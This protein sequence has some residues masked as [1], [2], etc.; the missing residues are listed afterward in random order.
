MKHRQWGLLL[1]NAAFKWFIIA[2]LLRLGAAVAIHQYSLANGFEGFYPLASGHD[3]I[4]YWKNANEV[5]NGILREPFLNMYPYILAG[6]FYITGPN[7]L[8]GKIL[9]VLFGALGV[10]FGV[11]LARELSLKKAG[12]AQSVRTAHWAGIMLT[13]YPS[14]VFYST[15]LLKD[16]A[17][18]LLA[19][20]ALYLMNRIA[21]IDSHIKKIGCGALLLAA[22]WLLYELR[23][24]SALVLLL[25]IVAYIL[26]F[27]RMAFILIVIAAGVFPY[28]L[29]YGF[30]GCDY[31]VPY[32]HK[33]AIG[34]QNFRETVYS[35][36]GSAAGNQLDFSSWGIFLKTYFFSFATLMFGPFPWQLKSTVHLIAMPEAAVMWLLSP[37]WFIGIIRLFDGLRRGMADKE[38]VLMIFS[39]GL[40]GAVALFSDNIGANTRLRILPWNVFMIYASLLLSQIKFPTFRKKG[41]PLS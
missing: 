12:E 39:L 19:I 9:N 24:Y 26:I 29:G 41:A 37:L 7:L 8:A 17:I 23:N 40:A 3:D 22:L 32:F 38:V 2:F 25:S 35:I 36:G 11:L 28:F 20:I 27:R 6:L 18:I 13:F 21:G 16:P 4:M 1:K 30:F 34:L 31:L 5:I 10:Y 14:S 15:Q 33:A